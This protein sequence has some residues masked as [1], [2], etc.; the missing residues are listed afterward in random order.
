MDMGNMMDRCVDA[1][2]SAMGSGMM[3]NGLLL[4]ILIALLLVWLVGLV[5]VGALGIWAVRNLSGA[6]RQ[7]S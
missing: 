7:G 6:S 3:G 1:M 5:A 4:V 2:G